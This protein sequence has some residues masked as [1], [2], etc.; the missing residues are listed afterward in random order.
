MNFAGTL[1]AAVGVPRLS[2]V[3]PAFN[4]AGSVVEAIESVFATGYPNLEVIVVDD[5]SSDDTLARVRDCAAGH[6]A[7]TVVVLT[8]PHG[9]NRGIV[10]SRNLAIGK[11][12]GRYLAFLD[13]DDVSYANRFIR[14][15][16]YLEAHAEFDAVFEPFEYVFDSGER[17]ARLQDLASRRRESPEARAPVLDPTSLGATELYVAFLQGRLPKSATSVTLRTDVF[18]RYGLFPETR[19]VTDRVLWLKL[20]AANR[21]VACGSDPVTGYRIHDQS[22]CARHAGKGSSL[23]GPLWALTVAYRWMRHAG[24]P[25]QNLRITFDAIRGKYFQY[26]SGILDR[27]YQAIPHLVVVP[28]QVVIAAPSLLLELRWWKALLVLWKRAAWR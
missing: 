12:S 15:V 5:G 3:I 2:V 19:I 17:S 24:V 1:A 22:I 21:I 10:A 26:C 13:A 20:F 6:A 11:A 23:A 18:A 25:E 27:S 8:H 28:L 16:P 4:C 14:S 9:E 7:G